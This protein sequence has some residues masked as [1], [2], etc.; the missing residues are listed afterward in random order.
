MNADE[1]HQQEIE[2]RQWLEENSEYEIWLDKN[3]YFDFPIYWEENY[4]RNS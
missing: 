2:Y 3:G 4:E 1:A